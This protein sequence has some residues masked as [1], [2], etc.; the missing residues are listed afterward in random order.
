MN[1]K[2]SAERYV[3]I[4]NELDPDR[5]RQIAQL[6]VPGGRYYVGEREVHVYEALERR[7]AGSHE[8]NM[9][10]GDHRGRK[11][12][13]RAARRRHPPLGDAAVRP[14]RGRGA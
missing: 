12:C 11:R 10:D 3:A 5:R 14:Q 7:I 1:A 9:C 6:W 13:S 2:S 8:K 4:C